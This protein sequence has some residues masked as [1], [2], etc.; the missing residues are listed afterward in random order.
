MLKFFKR[1]IW[2]AWI[3][4]ALLASACAQDEN[5]GAISNAEEAANPTSQAPSASE[6]QPNS[7]EKTNSTS[8][9]SETLIDPATLTIKDVT[10]ADFKSGVF[11]DFDSFQKSFFND[12]IISKLKR[13]LEAV[14]AQD[15][16]KFAADLDENFSRH[17]VFFDKQNVQYMFYD[18]DT[19]K[20]VDLDGR[21]Q[22]QVG[23][24]F[25]V[26]DSEGK[27]ENTG[28]T[29]FFVKNKEDQWKI[30]NID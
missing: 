25:A 7:P 21:V 14:V 11:I 2:F 30:A 18:L 22:I 19:L 28:L 17:S 4:G 3:A 26:K 10:E 15:Q 13:N 6:V 20:K 5:T 27:V 8:A 9:E 12:D 23:V 16:E 1:S 24:R 29:F